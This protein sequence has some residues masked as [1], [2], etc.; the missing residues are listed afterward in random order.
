MITIA[1][2]K[3]RKS[4]KKLLPMDIKADFHYGSRHVNILYASL[5]RNMRIPFR[6]ACITDDPE[7]INPD[8]EIIPLWDKCQYLGGCYNRL[9]IF[10]SDMKTILGE[11]FAC[12]D[13]DCV[14]T[15]D[16]TEIFSRKEEFVI[17]GYVPF[18]GMSGA[19]TQKYNGGLV[20]MNAGCRSQVWNS[21][22]PEKT[23]KLLSSL[24][25]KYVG[26]D[27]AWI[28]YVLGDKEAVITEEDGVYE[29]RKFN[30]KTPLPK[31]AKLIMFAGQ[32]DP[33][34]SNFT[35]VKNHWVEQEGICCG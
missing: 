7:G 1:C 5:K 29:A 14:V 10:S 9:Y 25:G 26:T 28:R 15:G 27:Q 22:D 35:W 18:R 16:V 17:N 4:E 30:T 24:R 12:I 2:F 6:F 20:I 3:W 13:L 33:S 11:R 31:A 19:M 23:P 21:F 8:I 32:R 34:R